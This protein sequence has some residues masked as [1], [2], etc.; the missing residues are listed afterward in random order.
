MAAGGVG[1]PELAEREAVAR[2]LRAARERRWRAVSDARENAPMG[3]RAYGTGSLFV[4]GGK[5][6][7]RWWLGNQRVKRALGPVRQ[8]G[9]REGLTR[10]QA[11]REMRRR[12]EAEAALVRSH[13]RL[14]LIEAG[15]RYVDHLEHVIERKRTTIQDY[16][17]YLR[18]HFEPY[19]GD[20]AIDRVESGHVMG[21]LK[22]KRVEGLSAKTVQNHLTFLHGVFAFAKRRGWLSSSPLLGVDRPRRAASPNRRIRFLQP[23]ELEATVR[24]VPDD[25][26]GG[27]ERA[28]Y[29]TAA[30]TGL[31]QGELL[32]LRWRDVDW[33]AGLVRVA[34]NFP[35][36]RVDRADSPKS[37]AGRSVPLA[38]RVARE[39]EGLFQRSRWQDDDDLVFCHPETGHVLDASKV[40]KRFRKA[41]GRARVREITFHEL[42]H[43]F[44]TQ[45]AAARVPLRAIQEWMGHADAKT[46]EVYRHY[47]PDPAGGATLVDRAFARGPNLGPNLSE[48]ESTSAEPKPARRAESD[49]G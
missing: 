20:R 42:R 9:S 25:E 4:K 14:T 15:E 47:T 12:M 48:S 7:G 33:V 41:L 43:T 18:G 31:R 35:R 24:A 37:H 22:R 36:G 38:D 39:L 45:L 1:R 19:F 11:E 30:M 3:R 34:D 29:L 8:P 28:L 49:P 26:L 16:R 40:R 27:V 10:A 5:W 23:E 44:G 46:T 21:Y 2:S 13:D 32:A 6:Y 17:G